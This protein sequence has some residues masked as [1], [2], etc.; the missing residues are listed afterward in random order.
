MGFKAFTQ[1]PN[2]T[3]ELSSFRGRNGEEEVKKK[4]LPEESLM[5]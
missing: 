2:I 1:D 5:N 4:R 3:K